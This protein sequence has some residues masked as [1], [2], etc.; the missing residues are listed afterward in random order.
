MALEGAKDHQRSFRLACQLST[1]VMRWDSCP[2]VSVQVGCLTGSAYQC[3]LRAQKPGNAPF[4]V[5]AK[6]KNSLIPLHFSYLNMISR[7]KHCKPPASTAL[8]FCGV[9]S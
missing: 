8:P 2:V 9:I 3:C 4:S 6:V 1:A 5:R 7:V